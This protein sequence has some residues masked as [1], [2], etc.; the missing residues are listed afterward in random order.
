MNV[1]RVVAGSVGGASSAVLIK[2]LADT[3]KDRRVKLLI[4]GAEVCVGI[5]AL[6]TGFKLSDEFWRAF[7]VVFGVAAVVSGGS[8]LLKELK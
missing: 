6:V 4:A 5:A 3:V 8:E 2:H 7:N 1:G